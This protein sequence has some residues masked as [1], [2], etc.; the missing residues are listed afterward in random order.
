MKLLHSADWHLDSPLVARAPEQAQLLRQSLLRVPSR[1][2]AAAKAAS[3]DLLLLSGDLFDGPCTA[4]SLKALK[5]ALEEAAIPVFIAPGNHDPVSPGS[6]WVTEAWPKNVHIFTSASMTSVSIP[7]LDCCIYGAAFTGQDSP[8]LL[9]DFRA[10]CQE[11]FAIGVLHGDPTQA[12]SPYNPITIE[13]IRESGLDYLALGHIHKGD[14]LRAGSTLCAWP[15]CPMGRG[16]DE[17]GP[18]GVLAVTLEDT[19]QA[20]FQPLDGLR[21]YDLEAETGLDPAAA[22]SRLLPAVGSE[23]FYRIT[24]TGECA[25]LNTASLTKQFSQF[26]NLELRDRTIPPVDL[27]GSAGDDT[28][29]GIYFAMLR[30]ALEGQDETT[31]RQIR[32][33][34]RISRQLLDGQEVTLP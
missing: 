15:G 34:A 19:V 24:L 11:R 28:L 12:D 26:P 18:K 10:E 17:L 5:D 23:D 3:C 8:A 7:E 33:A 6:P 14:F 22:L 1:V 2:A 13:Q 20:Q 27:W 9:H 25:S 4:G 16:F 21:F 31:Q 32:L 30:N 29:E